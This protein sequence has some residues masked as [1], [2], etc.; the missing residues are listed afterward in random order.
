MDRRHPNASGA[1]GAAD[2]PVGGWAE[3]P[4]DPKPHLAG[5]AQI[6]GHFVN[7]TGH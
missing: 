6:I 5:F 7:S 4:R 3:Q 1:E 2:A